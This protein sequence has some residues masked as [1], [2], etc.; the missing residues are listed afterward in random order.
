M[1][2]KTAFALA[3]VL[4]AAPVLVPSTAS[5]QVAP[6]QTSCEWAQLEDGN[7]ICVPQSPQ[8]YTYQDQPYAYYYVPNIGWGWHVSPWGYGHPWRGRWNAGYGHHAPRYYGG[9][10][11][12]GGGGHASGGHHG[13]GH[14]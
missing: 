7:W 3:G 14:R 9:H 8:V 12:H 11:G 6:V 2:T 10:A 13:G 1:I 5:A 4:A